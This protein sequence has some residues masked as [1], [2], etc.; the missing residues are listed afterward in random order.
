MLLFF[1]LLICYSLLLNRDIIKLLSD[2]KCI[3]FELLEYAHVD[4]YSKNF[5]EF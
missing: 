3:I 5:E 4:K 1:N 2:L